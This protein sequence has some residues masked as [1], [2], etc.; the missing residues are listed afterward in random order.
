MAQ[1]CG[2]VTLRTPMTVLAKQL[3]FELHDADA[4]PRYSS[5]DAQ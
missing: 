2:R 1:M 5:K 3:Q 4:V